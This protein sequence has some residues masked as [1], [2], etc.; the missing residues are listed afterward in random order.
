MRKKKCYIYTRVSTMAQTEG[1]SLEAQ[2]ER[3]REYAE[4]RNLQIVGEYCDAGKSGKSIKGRPA[5]Q[6]MMDD[7]VNGKD[8]VSYVL[9]FKL[10]RF[11]RNAADV[12][13]SM[14]LLNDY[15]VDLVC[16]DDAI[17]S[18]TQ[19][20]RL[21]LAILS[22]V[23]EIERENITVQFN[24]G[25]MQKV[26][27]GG[28]PGGPVPYGYRNIKKQMQ[29][30]PAEAELVKKMFEAFLI[31][32]MTTTSVAAYMNEQGYRRVIKGEERPFTYDFVANALENPF[33][34]GKILY[35]KRSK[36]K[37]VMAIQGIHE[38]IVD[39]DLWKQ[40]QAKRK[41]L[42]VKW[43]KVDDS[44]RISILSGLVKCP[45]CGKG[46]IAT[47][48]KHVNKNR[49]GHYKTIHYYSCRNHR[50]SSGRECSFNRQLNQSKID[51]SVFEI[52]SGITALPEYHEMIANVLGNQP[53]VELLENE[54]KA[55]RK[56]LRSYETQKRKLGEELDGLD[57]LDDD[58]D[59]NYDR[60]QSE[61]DE[62]YDRMDDAES[63]ISKIKKKLSATKNGIRSIEK[64]KELVE[65]M[66][67]LFP[68]MT[69]DEQKEMYR[70]FIERID[71]YP[72]EQDNGKLIKSITF[73]F[74]VYYEDYETVPTKTPDDQIGFVL[75]CS[76][77]G[78]TVAE[79]KATYAEIKAYVKEK[80]GAPVHSLYIAQIK[81][82]YGLDMG[83][84]YNL[85]KKENARV[86]TCPKEKE[87]Y[88][89]DALKHFRMLDMSVEMEA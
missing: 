8:D 38:P 12:L 16:V 13:K 23:A 55:L 5:F 56:Q 74:P 49:G 22:A 11:G 29:I 89:V 9:V 6:E 88:I 19:G 28:W 70:L 79:A 15:D 3:L 31:D 59:E 71:V 21:T 25:R 87:A 34:C 7:I 73:K 1:Y 48:N 53:S 10:S 36:K 51:S 40:V 44:E 17:D 30:E 42:S 18:S 64:V 58:Y 27:E 65:H 78:L 80:Y 77:L 47:K 26:L 67:L 60:I 68:K 63:A 32:G 85:S 24:A 86:P 20:G 2:V 39:E 72:E 61:M 14:Q 62:I 37:D 75:D 52:F 66:Q 4:Y 50:K 35:G 57:I 46:M 82:K 54:L 33:Y 81:K 84:N 41:E 76:T 45:L 83:V 69:C 43:Q